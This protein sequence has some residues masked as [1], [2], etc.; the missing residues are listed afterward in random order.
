MVEPLGSRT[1]VV[2]GVVHVKPLLRD[3]KSLEGKKPL[4]QY[5]SGTLTKFSTFSGC[6]KDKYSL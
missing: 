1:R 4:E 6:V 2:S 3:F 5:F